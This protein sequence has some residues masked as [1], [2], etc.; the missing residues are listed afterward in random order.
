MQLEFLLLLL[1]PLVSGLNILMSSTDSWVSKNP[2]YLYRALTEKGHKVKYV[3]PLHAHNNNN[4]KDRLLQ[5]R[6]EGSSKRSVGGDFDHLMDALQQFYKNYRRANMLARGAKNVMRKK[7]LEEFD[8]EYD[9]PLVSESFMGQDP[10]NRNFWYVA[11]D[12]LQALSV[13]FSEILPK[14]TPDFVPDLVLIGPNEGLHLSS[15]MDGG[16]VGFTMEDLAN[17]ENQVE[18]MTQLANINQYAVLAAS[19]QDEDNIYYE[20]ESFFNIEERKYDNLFKDNAISE[21]VKFVNEKVVKLVSDLAFNLEPYASLNVNF[22]S[23]NH[24]ESTCFTRGS[25]APDFV[26]ITRPQS[27]TGVYGKILSIPE[28]RIE[29]EVVIS[30][31]DLDFKVSEELQEVKQIRLVEQLR[32]KYL[33]LNEVSERESTNRAEK[34][35]VEEFEALKDCRIAVSV[36]HLTKGNNLDQS[37]LNIVHQ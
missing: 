27:Q 20:D 5:K 11:G 3:G 19:V 16:K 6:A 24:K 13:A 18:A 4:Y 35:N 9:S 31:E 17:K 15:R 8:A 12:P 34:V 28:V 7:D 36:N 2:R 25:S 37:Y 33:M 10:L 1:I 22:P 23:L 21:N 14:H 26:Q 30:G 32:M 29:D